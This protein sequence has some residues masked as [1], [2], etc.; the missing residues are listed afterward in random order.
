MVRNKR[1]HYYSLTH[2]FGRRL[3]G[4]AFGQEEA[5]VIITNIRRPV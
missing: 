2:V 5:A 3:G 1:I 4:I